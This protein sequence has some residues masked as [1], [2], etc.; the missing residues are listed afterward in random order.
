M[1]LIQSQPV[2][3]GFNGVS[4]TF[5]CT[6]TPLPHV[7]QYISTT[8]Y[9]RGKREDDRAESEKTIEQDQLISAQLAIAPASNA[10]IVRRPRP[11]SATT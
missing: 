11:L 4:G 1:R 6:N 5:G 8:R 3:R 2:E 9:P 7:I 10:P